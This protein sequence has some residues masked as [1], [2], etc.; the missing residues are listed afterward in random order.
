MEIKYLVIL[1]CVLFGFAMT[2]M[3]F[4]EYNQ[5]ECKRAAIYAQKPANEII[6]ICGN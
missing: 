2:G 3:L 4:E 6:A 1:A 5:G